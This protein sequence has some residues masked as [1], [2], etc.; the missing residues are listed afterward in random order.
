MTCSWLP[1][2]WPISWC[3]TDRATGAD[4]GCWAWA[5]N[6]SGNASPASTAKIMASG[7]DDPLWTRRDIVPP[8]KP[9]T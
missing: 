7:P 2:A 8:S 9:D 4:T 1:T 3:S 5:G 6:A